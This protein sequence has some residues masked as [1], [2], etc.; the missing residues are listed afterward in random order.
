M[1]GT[2]DFVIHSQRTQRES[3]YFELYRCFTPGGEVELSAR[4]K[5]IGKPFMAY[6]GTDDG[7]PFIEVKNAQGYLLNGRTEIRQI[8]SGAVLGSYTR[9]NAVLDAAGETLARWRD[10]RRWS[11]EFRE[12]LFDALAN[13]AL[14]AG[15]VP[16]GS[17]SS[18][19]H[20]LSCGNKVLARLQ[21]ERMHFHPD[22][23]R[24]ESPGR[25]AKIVGR[26]IPGELG[27]SMRENLPPF[28]WSLF[29]A[30]NLPPQFSHSFLLCTAILRI[31]MLRYS[32]ST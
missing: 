7:D 24:S 21:R 30:E 29:L 26:M 10:A 18:D 13:A 14:G 23:P 4:A 2:A 31:Q 27:R 17:N 12:N 9:L 6:R 11:E 16:G 32:R 19:T 8:S 20:L 22:P 5:R 1:D 28:G 3:V 15:D 25:I